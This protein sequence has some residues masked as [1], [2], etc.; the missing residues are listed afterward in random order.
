MTQQEMIDALRGGPVPHRTIGDRLQ[1]MDLSLMPGGLRGLFDGHGMFIGG[2]VAELTAEPSPPDI[3]VNAENETQEGS[4]ESEDEGQALRGRLPEDF[5][6]HAALAAAGVDTYG[7]LRKVS[8]LTEIEGIG[9]ATAEKIQE[10][11]GE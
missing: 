9:P 8:D 5:P 11:L 10:A 4:D 1:V 6:G 3:Q 7:K 2:E